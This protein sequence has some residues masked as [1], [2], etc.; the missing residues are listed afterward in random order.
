[1]PRPKKYESAAVKQR[2][3]RTR[4]KER[5]PEGERAYHWRLQ[6][7]HAIIQRAVD[8]GDERAREFL[9]VNAYDT[10][11]RLIFHSQPEE[12]LADDWFG[13][14]SLQ[15][16]DMAL[17]AYQEAAADLMLKQAGKR[18]GVFMVSAS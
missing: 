17:Y 11:L 6:K 10:A 9:G 14:W 3:Y 15:G 7:L 1:M 4:L 5:E 12:D 8:A 13:G 2:A 18:D 16:F